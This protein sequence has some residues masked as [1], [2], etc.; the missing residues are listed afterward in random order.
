MSPRRGVGRLLTGLTLSALLS[1]C[2]RGGPQAPCRRAQRSVPNT[3][4]IPEPSK[5]LL[6]LRGGAH[7]D[8]L[9]PELIRR[10]RALYEQAEAEGIQLRLISGYRAYRPKRRVKRGGSLASWHAFGA[11]V[12]LNL[13]G[14]K[15]M[16]DALK[17]LDEDLK[18][19]ERVGAIA[20]GLGLTWGYQWGKK[21]I[22]HFEWHPGL[23]DAIR[24]PTLQK[25]KAKTGGALKE[26]YQE[27]WELFQ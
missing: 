26:R 27:A 10:V 19:W 8:G 9:H 25:I 2:C 15:G 12:D 6:E 3:R 22:F 14:R 21:E 5:P 13:Q 24:A 23:P 20:E 18:R 17:H 11:A 4:P 1:A 16:S 7:L